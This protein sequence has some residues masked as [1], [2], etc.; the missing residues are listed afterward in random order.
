MTKPAHL[1]GYAE[2]VR[3]KRHQKTEEENT[4]D[5]K[6][7]VA[8]S[9]R[10]KD[11]EYKNELYEEF[12]HDC[13]WL[14]DGYGIRMN[15]RGLDRDI[16]FSIYDSIYWEVERDNSELGF[17]TNDF[18]ESLKDAVKYYNHDDKVSR[19]AWRLISYVKR[20]WVDYISDSVKIKDDDRL[21]NDQPYKGVHI[22]FNM[23]K[24]KP[25]FINIQNKDRFGNPVM[26]TRKKYFSTPEAAKAFIDEHPE[27]S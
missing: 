6:Q 15:H 12:L 21:Y 25:Y 22:F 16:S 1:R 13:Y 4:E 19:F 14:A 11:E 9:Y 5:E 23:S 24:S 3:A 10:I 8:D 26:S 20:N 27:L 17:N 7:D 18:V 2:K